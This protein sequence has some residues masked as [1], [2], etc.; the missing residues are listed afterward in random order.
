M[1][2]AWLSWRVYPHQKEP[3]AAHPPQVH[4]AASAGTGVGFANAGT[5]RRREKRRLVGFILT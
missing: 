4:V 5:A 3:N 2:F 1:A